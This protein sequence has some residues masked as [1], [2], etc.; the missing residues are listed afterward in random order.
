MEPLHEVV[1]QSQDRKGGRSASYELSLLGLYSSE[2]RLTL[3]KP[4]VCIG[5]RGGKAESSKRMPRE[6]YLIIITISIDFGAI[7][8]EPFVIRTNS[9][10][11][12]S[13]K[14]CLKSSKNNGIL[15]SICFNFPN[16]N[17]I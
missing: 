17:A 14:L 8:K 11:P 13:A 10:N 1:R 4:C 6:L 9:Q 5:E 2:G 3:Q 15:L 7:L 12:K 16:S